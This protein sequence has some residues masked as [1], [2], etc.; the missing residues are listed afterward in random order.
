M[1]RLFILSVSILLQTIPVISTNLTNSYASNITLTVA[2]SPYY[3][4]S[5]INIASTSTIKIENG[6][7]IIFMDDFTISGLGYI[8]ACFSYDTTSITDT[9]G[10]SNPNT[11]IHIH[12][13]YNKN[14]IG[15]IYLK[16]GDRKQFA[17]FCNVK[18]EN[19]YYSMR[20][21]Q[22]SWRSHYA[23]DNCEI[24]N[25]EYGTYDSSWDYNYITSTITDT[26][27]HN[28][29]RV[30]WIQG[31][32]YDH[33]IMEEFSTFA[34]GGVA[35][36][37]R[38]SKIYGPGT[39]IGIYMR[40]VYDGEESTGIYNNVIANFDQCIRLFESMS[41]PDNYGLIVSSNNISNCNTYGMYID[42]SNKI[43]I[44]NN[45]FHSN[46]ADIY[47]VDDGDHIIQNNTFE[48][49]VDN[50]SIYLD[51]SGDVDIIYNLF[52]YN[53]NKYIVYINQQN[54]GNGRFDVLENTFMYNQ[55]EYLI[56]IDDSQG[57]YIWV[58]NNVF[59]NNN[60]SYLIYGSF[61]KSSSNS[62]NFNYNK[63]IKN[64]ANRNL[65]Y[66]KYG[67]DIDIRYNMF[68]GNTIDNG[69]IY[70]QTNERPVFE[71]NTFINNE[72]LSYNNSCVVKFDCDGDQAY[73]NSGT[74]KPDMIF[75]HNNLTNNKL[76]SSNTLEAISSNNLLDF[77]D[78]GSVYIYRNIFS[79]R[80][81]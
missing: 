22:T 28:V 27:I 33:C 80:T 20:I 10:L 67:D 40:G 70:I 61:P 79:N 24:T 2:G 6:A 29:T 4:I 12:G 76:Q 5:D 41:G 72:I 62:R 1:Y 17:K 52:M 32:I 7:E 57:T 3:V 66:F 65:L 34:S 43:D 46:G 26:H 18:F 9:V 16:N 11:Y 68:D 55:N 44:D 59:S 48:Y 21:G 19:M 8:N 71:Y 42:D 14:R 47:M 74:S 39:G 54:S 77:R 25:C 63:F 13:D 49:N 51:N 53:N 58:N 50:Y 69:L 37:V 81:L 15:K 73:C 56:Y 78:L 23:I 75:K 31:Y 60:I 38:N 30:N 64:N 36:A 45:H 35:L